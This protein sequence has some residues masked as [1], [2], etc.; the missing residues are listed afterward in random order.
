MECQWERL[1]LGTRPIS[2][3]RKEA[4]LPKRQTFDVMLDSII[5][6]VRR[7]IFNISCSVGGPLG[8][9]FKFI[10]LSDGD[11][12]DGGSGNRHK[13]WHT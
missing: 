7:A 10:E 6:V 13:E 1:T 4:A 2:A 9:I 8:G 12:G 5:S 11:A 3:Q